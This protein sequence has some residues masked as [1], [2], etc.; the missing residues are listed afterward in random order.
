M[1]ILSVPYSQRNNHFTKKDHRIIL[2][3]YYDLVIKK[4]ESQMFEG[5]PLQIGIPNSYMIQAIHTLV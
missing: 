5:V 1:D 4:L 2:Y 3:I